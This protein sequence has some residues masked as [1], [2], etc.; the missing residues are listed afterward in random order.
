MLSIA[1]HVRNGRRDGFPSCCI[2]WFC[3]A[4]IVGV[5]NL[6]VRSGSIKPGDGRSGWVACRAHRWLDPRWVPVRTPWRCEPE[7]A[8]LRE[9]I[10]GGGR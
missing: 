7:Q 2:T 1:T 10:F 4:Q 3:L 6:A 5:E 9:R 8:G